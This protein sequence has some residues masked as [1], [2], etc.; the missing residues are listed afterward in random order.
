MFKGIEPDNTYHI[1]AKKLWRARLFDFCYD[2]NWG[3]LFR[4]IGAYT[5]LMVFEHHFNVNFSLWEATFLG[6]GLGLAI[7]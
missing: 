3:R 6:I 5:V 1:I 4:M 2:H 7:D